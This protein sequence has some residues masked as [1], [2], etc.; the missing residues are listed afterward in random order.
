MRRRL[1]R[2][3]VAPS[4]RRAASARSATASVDPSAVAGRR[5]G[6]PAA[7][8]D[9]AD[10]GGAKPAPHASAHRHQRRAFFFN[11]LTNRQHRQGIVHPDTACGGVSVEVARREQP[12]RL[13]AGCRHVPLH[14]G[15]RLG[16]GQQIAQQSDARAHDLGTGGR[17]ARQSRQTAG[18]A[19]ARP[20]R[21]R[22]RRRAAG[23]QGAQRI[24]AGAGG[25]N[26]PFDIAS[27][28]GMI[29]DAEMGNSI[30][31]R[32]G[33]SRRRARCAAGAARRP[34]RSCAAGSRCRRRARWTSRRSHSPTRA[35]RAPSG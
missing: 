5:D 11:R 15:R 26:R 20:C 28:R 3:D 34:P 1:L 12:Q 24:A 8:D 14:D 35:R 7:R 30:M 33:R 10:A 31:G 13:Q 4:P 25:S 22:S 17:D 27:N 2:A 16:G 32:A 9:E 19:P 21:R 6:S 18:G 23:A 29:A